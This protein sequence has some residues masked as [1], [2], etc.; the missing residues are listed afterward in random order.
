MPRGRC[1][2]SVRVEPNG[3]YT[4]PDLVGMCEPEFED[5]GADT[6]I[7]PVLI[8]EVLSPSTEAYDR[9]LKF[10]LYRR[11]ETLRE[12]VLVAQDR[13]SVEAYRRGSERQWVL[14]EHL[15]S[16]DEF[17]LTSMGARISLDEL[18]RRVP[19]KEISLHA[20]SEVS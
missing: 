10:T 9:G 20:N 18:Y 13:L 2:L 12:Y 15:A 11:S 14:S 8:V 7:N 3:L 4:Y 5:A 16:G 19:L 6:L 1:R 17:E